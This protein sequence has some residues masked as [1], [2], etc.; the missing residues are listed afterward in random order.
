MSK[1]TSFQ[2]DFVNGNQNY[3][4]DEFTPEYHILTLSGGKDS[5]ALALHI[6]ENYPNIHKKIQYSRILRSN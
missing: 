2:T 4:A 6:K 5:A 1:F 3:Y